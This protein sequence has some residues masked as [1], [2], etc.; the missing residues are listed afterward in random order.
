MSERYPPTV[1]RTHLRLVILTQYYP[2]ETGAPQGRL[3]DLATRLAARGHEVTVFTAMPNYPT[4]RVLPDWRGKVVARENRDGVEV[5]RSWIAPTATRSTPRQLWTYLTFAGSVTVTAPFRLRWADV[6]LWESPPLFLAPTARLLA[7]R[8]GARLVMNVS[9]LWPRAAV[10]LGVI[11]EGRLLAAFERLERRA[12]RRAALVSCQTEG[13]A[14]GVRARE[15]SARTFVYPNGVDVARF[16]RS[17]VVPEDRAALG[18]RP[19]TFAVGYAG[20]FGRFQALDQVVDAAA[21]L[22]HRDDIEFV[23]LGDGPCRDDVVARARGLDNL[24]VLDAVPN[25]RIPPILTALDAAIV[26]LANVPV[27]AGARPAKMFELAA[28][29]VPFVYCGSGEG[30]AIA[31]RCAMPVVPPERPKEL[32]AAIEELAALPEDRRAR[33][34]AAGRAHVVAHFD[35]ADIAE[36]MERELLALLQR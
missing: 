20:N 3:S 5:K 7:K 2:P 14:S 30:A 12:Y 33:M 26:P 32:A 15:P 21:A 35:R 25:V 6:L 9:D 16:D 17:R 4:G 22:R 24:R 23:M 29:E 13:V 1:S 34:G 36:R 10:D 8:L 28:L 18:L 11:R 31:E 19:G 27:Q